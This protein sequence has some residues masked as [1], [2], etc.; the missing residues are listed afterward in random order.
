MAERII[1]PRSTG[2]AHAS[3]EQWKKVVI[4]SNLEE[5]VGQ[6]AVTETLRTLIASGRVQG[7]ALDHVLL[8]GPTGSGR[9]ALAQVIASEL[10]IRL[11]V[12]HAGAIERAGDFAAILTNLHP[13]DLLLMEE[14]HLLGISV[15]E[16]LAPAMLDHVLDIVIGKGPGARSVRLALPRFTIVGTTHLPSVIPLSAARAFPL[17]F[18]LRE[19]T[20]PE[21]AVIALRA[22][23]R[24]DLDLDPETRQTIASLSQGLPRRTLQLLHQWSQLSD[25]H[26]GSLPN[27]EAL[28][29]LSQL[30]QDYRAVVEAARP[31]QEPIVVH[32]ERL[33]H[34][35]ESRLEEQLDSLEARVEE[36]ENKADE[37]FGG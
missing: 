10:G 20:V 29:R 30:A 8:V 12:T 27:R 37:W 5:F 9:T 13:G 36:I 7:T 17:V 34:Q 21:L 14:I 26:A 35:L 28:A 24:L 2:D 15:A 4:P 11:K 16:V 1:S 6:E 22:A 32:V 33:L 23:E 19:Y 25:Q 31:E 18:H 3:E